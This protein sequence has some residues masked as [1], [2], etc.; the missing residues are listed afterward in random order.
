MRREF[1]LPAESPAIIMR[2]AILHSVERAW[3]VRFEAL[4]VAQWW[5]PKGYINPI[6]EI[7]PIQGGHWRISQ[8][9]PEGNE[10]SFYGVFTE[11]VP[12]VRTVQSYTSELFPELP[13]VLTTEFHATPEGTVVV[14]TH[15]YPD[16]VTRTGA[17]RLGVIERMSESSDRYEELLSQ[18][19]SP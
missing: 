8:R 15:M 9:D 5:R 4:Y 19:R 3:T 10:F 17:L 2:E 14:S 6:V 13:T 11:V 16:D 12:L 7:D 18:L 1:S